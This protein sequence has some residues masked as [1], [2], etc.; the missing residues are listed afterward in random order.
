MNFLANKPFVFLSDRYE[1]WMGGRCISQGPIQAKITAKIDDKNIGFDIEGAD[2]LRMKKHGL[3]ALIN[4]GGMSLD[5]GTR[6]QYFNP[7][8]IPEDPQELIL[9]HVFY[10]GRTITYLRFAMSYPDRIIEFYGKAISFDGMERPEISAGAKLPSFKGLFIDQ[11][12]DHYRKLLKE[13]TVSLA[14]VDHQLACVAF[15]LK[16]LLSMKAMVDDSND[17]LKSQIFKDAS[18]IIYQFYPISGGDALENTR[19]W[20]NQLASD[21]TRAEA[22]LEYYEKAL[23]AGTKIDGFKAQELFHLM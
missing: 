8:F 1:E 9:C 22:F 10:D 4:T 23:I 11:I 21:T 16:R 19:S 18:S 14:I 17:E 12:A 15:S 20:Y 6:L 2:A 13:N 3:F 5:M 7:S